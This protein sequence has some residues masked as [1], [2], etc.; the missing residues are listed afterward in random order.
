MSVAEALEVLP[1]PLFMRVHRSYIIGLDHIKVIQRQ[2]ATIGEVEIPIGDSYR[3][4]F[5]RRVKYSG[6]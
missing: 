5:F 2:F 6:N 3:D 4:A 1:Q